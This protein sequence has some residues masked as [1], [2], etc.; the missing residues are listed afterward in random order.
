MKEKSS[1]TV[2]L[3]IFLLINPPVHYLT[4][5]K[6]N[7]CRLKRT[8]DQSINKKKMYCGKYC[9]SH[10]GQSQKLL[11]MCLSLFLSRTLSHPCSS[12]ASTPPPRLQ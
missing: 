6:G 1:T 10:R 12:L 4:T 11:V 7:V 5:K 2:Y 9:S 8:F 3:K